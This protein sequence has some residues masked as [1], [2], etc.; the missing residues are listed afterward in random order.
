MTGL[1]SEKRPVVEKV[2]HKDADV[3][4]DQDTVDLNPSDTSPSH[5]SWDIPAFLRQK[6]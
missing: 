2:E 6:R 1:V 3:P 5:D 4:E